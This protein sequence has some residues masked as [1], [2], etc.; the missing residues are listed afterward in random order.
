MNTTSHLPVIAGHEISMDE[1]GRFNLN[2]IHRAGGGE[3][4]KRPSM[5][6]QNGQ[7]KELIGEFENQSRNS[8]FAPVEARRG[9]K[10][11][12]TY[13]VDLLAISYAGWISPRF[14]LQVN[15]VFLDYRMGRLE[16]KSSGTASATLTPAHQQGLRQA[17]NRRVQALP[18]GIQR[19]AYARLYGHLHS[20]FS[21]AK[22]QQID[23]SRYTEALAAIETCTLEGDYIEAATKSE[24]QN[25]RLIDPDH[26]ADVLDTIVLL[27]ELLPN[28]SDSMQHLL[29]IVQRAH[30]LLLDH[31]N[32]RWIC[33]VMFREVVQMKKQYKAHWRLPSST[34]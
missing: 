2:A 1:H 30:K 27:S 25:T 32:P 23:D 11:S 3:N 17:I 24:P 20:R 16:A 7:T 34:A 31:R 6:M 33:G 9:G 21:V 5:W 19:T 22:Y 8:C 26:L 15:Q 10:V 18:K 4:R 28:P 29:W 14:Q 12:G 13:A